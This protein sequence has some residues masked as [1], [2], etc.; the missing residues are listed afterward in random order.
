[1]NKQKENEKIQ[2]AIKFFKHAP[3][4]ERKPYLLQLREKGAEYNGFVFQEDA[5]CWFVWKPTD[6]DT[7]PQFKGESLVKVIPRTVPID[8]IP[9][10]LDA[11][12]WMYI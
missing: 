4:R 8:K 11:Q 3:F 2:E 10:I 1:M 12:P 7:Q 6:P 5:W 9:D